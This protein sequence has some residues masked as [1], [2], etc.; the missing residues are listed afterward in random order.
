VCVC[1]SGVLSTL[2]FP[3]RCGVR[4]AV[5]PPFVGEAYDTCDCRYEV[6]W[7]GGGGTN[8]I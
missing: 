7:E 2:V 5:Y 6:T 3:L 8:T 1:V 4:G